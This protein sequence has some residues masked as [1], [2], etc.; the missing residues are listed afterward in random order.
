MP[1]KEDEFD[2]LVTKYRWMKEMDD[3]SI[4]TWLLLAS[5]FDAIGA[6]IHAG[7]CRGR[8]ADIQSGY[9]VCKLNWLVKAYRAFREHERMTK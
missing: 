8:A 7:L 9:H 6:V 4:K 1:T 5:S 3:S 2:S